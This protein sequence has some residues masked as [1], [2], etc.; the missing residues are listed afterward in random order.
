M[1]NTLLEFH[2]IVGICGA[3]AVLLAYFLLQTKRVSA[4]SLPYSLV[5]L[6]GAVLI[7]FSLTNAWNLTAVFIE[8]AWGF[9]SVMGII[10][11]WKTTYLEK[12]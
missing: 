9:L 1:K 7:L 5:N 10:K 2:D 8:I 4:H 3:I 12:N 6:T 11:W